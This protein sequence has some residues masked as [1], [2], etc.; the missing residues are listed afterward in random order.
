MKVPDNQNLR[1]YIEHLRDEG[2]TV[3]DGHTPDPDLI[4]PQGNPVYT[5]QEGYPY[6]TRMDRDEYEL[7]K[8]RLQV[9]LLKYQ[10]WLEDNDQ[11]S[12]IIFEGRDA[13]G[14]GG[15]IKRFTEHLNP[16]TARVVALNKPSDR[17][18]GQWYFQR[19]IQHLPTE[20]E[21]VLF[22]RSWY[23]RAG[24]ERVM[25]FCTD[26]EYEGFMN[27]APLFER[28]L[29]DSGI[30]LTKLW[31]S[32]SQREQRTRFAIRQLDP[33]RRWKLSPMDLESLDRWE[34]YTEAKEEMFRR[35]DKKYAPWTIIRSNDKKRA[36]LNAMR[37]FL[38]QFEY[39][40]KDHEVVGEP[41]PKL[42]MRG[43]KEEADE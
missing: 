22:D 2:Y 3:A 13:A 37:Y 32:V 42:V 26:E 38:S 29:V 36:R 17:E 24:V 43:K 27:Q 9:E 28:M 40:G 8:Y 12:I 11:K 33:V 7:E 15:T 10:Y 20:G 41:D 30:H 4:D 5:W 34:A 23:N 21:M 1:E 6:D 18:K 25:G 31:F 19:Y 16:R 35:T 14:K 39:E